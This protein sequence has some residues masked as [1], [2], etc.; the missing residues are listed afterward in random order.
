VEEEAAMLAS[1][2]GDEESSFRDGTGVS[3]K[4]A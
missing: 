1:A 2:E 3:A 4:R